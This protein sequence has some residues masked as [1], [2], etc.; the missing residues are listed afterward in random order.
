MTDRRRN[1]ILLLISFLFIMFVTV[2]SR[3]PSLSRTTHF[4][5]FWSYVSLFNGTMKYTTQI[6]LNI[7]LFIP[8]SY[9]LSTLLRPLWTVLISLGT[10]AMVETIQFMTY[11]GMLDV[12]DLLS[13]VLGAFIG[14]LLWRLVVKHGSEKGKKQIV[15]ILLTAVL[16]GCITVMGPDIEKSEKANITQQFDFKILS[17][18]TDIENRVIINGKCYVYER[19]NLTYELLTDGKEVKKESKGE[20]FSAE[21][22]LP[23]TKTEVQIRFNGFQP[24]STGV[25]LRPDGKIDFV[26]GSVIQPEGVPEG[27]V[28]KAYSSLYDTYV[29][30]DQGRILWFIGWNQLDQN[31]EVIFHLRTNEPEKLPE[32]R[33][34]YGFDNRGF[35]PKGKN[36]SALGHELEKVGKYRIFTCAIPSD[37]NITAINVGFNTK[38]TVTWWESFRLSNQR[39]NQYS[40]ICRTTLMCWFYTSYVQNPMSMM[41]GQMKCYRGMQKMNERIKQL[42]HHFGLSQAQLAQR[43]DRQE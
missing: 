32:N 25:W 6:L 40:M 1:I 7:A 10:S 22:K 20:Y 33:K 36:N 3:Q 16:I 38:G 31:T 18:D 39:N 2:I 4:Q 30:E 43:K 23:T 28:L 15:G 19:P 37:Y 17:I 21:M 24:M 11:R 35:Y 14:V 34:Q 41:S 27:A 29:Y 9:F 42:R 13:N 26:G 8:Y 5:L 12:D